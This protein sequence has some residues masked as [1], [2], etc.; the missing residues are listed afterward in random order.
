MDHLEDNDEILVSPEYTPKRLTRNRTKP[1]KYDEFLDMTPVKRKNCA[2]VESSDEEI[3]ENTP[4]PKAL[5][6][7]DDVDG[8]D[9]FKFKS[10]HTKNDLYNK[11]KAV[12]SS[13]INSPM[14]TPRK[15]LLQKVNEATPRH[16]VNIMKKKIIQAVHSNS[17]DSDFSGSSSDFI[18]DKSGD[19]SSS[20]SSGTDSEVEEEEGTCKK[21]NVQITK[22][23]NNRTK[24]KDTEY[25]VT[26]DN[27]FMMNS[28]K[29]I[30]TSDHT[31]A[32]LKMMN[33]NENMKEVAAYM[34]ERHRDKVGDLVQTYDQLFDKWVYVLSENFNVILYGIGSK[35]AVLQRFQTEKLQDTPCIVVNGFFP[36]LTIKNILETVVIDFLENTHVPSNI[37][38]VV[39]LIEAQLDELG[40]DL[41]LIVHNIDGNMLRNSK[42]QSVLASLAQLK[43]VHLIATIDHINAP[44]LWD[45]SKL[46][47][48]NFTWWDVTTFLPY[49]DETSYENSLMTQRSGALQLSSL[50]SVF[51]SLTSNAKGIFEIIIQYQLENQKQ[52]HYQGL[53]FKDLYSKARE[54]FLVSSDLA[55]RAQLTEFLDHKLVKIKRTL[56]GSENLVIPIESSLLQQFL[57]QQIKIQ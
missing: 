42:A 38:D 31:L 28:S 36:S 50:K 53:P 32:R 7:N 24:P 54:Q 30:T 17:S 44:L 6:G 34:S 9:I 52:V 47:K 21:G 18:P 11:A 1:K 4:K 56:D 16:V 57:D 8:Q 39:S 23:R 25:F 40:V 41:F 2:Y 12:V 19:E 13:S 15:K 55:L 5:F 35:R 37:G 22:H 27:Y 10:R 46:S 51:Q 20:S 43:N 3:Q 14:K 49:V 45:H 48:F 29:K 33:I 26:P